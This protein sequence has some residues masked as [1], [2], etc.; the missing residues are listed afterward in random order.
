M[1]LADELIQRPRSH[2]ISKR[3]GA[4]A[5]VLVTRDGL[6]KAHTLF[7]HRVTETQRKIGVFQRAARKSGL[8]A[9]RFCVLCDSVSLWYTGLQD[10]TDNALGQ[11][12]DIEID[13]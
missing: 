4:I 2:T 9:Q 1:L 12:W 3:P 8:D 10:A 6:E 7:H 5:G 13:Q 11:K